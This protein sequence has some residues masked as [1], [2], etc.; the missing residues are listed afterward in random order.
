MTVAELIARL[1]TL[2]SDAPVVYR[3]YEYDHLV[4]ISAAVLAPAWPVTPTRAR[5]R[6]WYI[7]KPHMGAT[8]EPVVVLEDGIL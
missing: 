4:E 3:D 7:N 8:S 2:P 6:L 1:Q 5:T